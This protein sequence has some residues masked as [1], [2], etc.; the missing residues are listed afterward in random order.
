MDLHA[1]L[2]DYLAERSDVDAKRIGGHSMH[3][4]FIWIPGYWS[5][6]ES[7]FGCHSLLGQFLHLCLHDG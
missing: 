5:V 4:C 3:I 1:Y 6:G 7:A 2:I